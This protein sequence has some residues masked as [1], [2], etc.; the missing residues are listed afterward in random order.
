MVR[1]DF[2]TE[3]FISLD[4]RY[5]ANIFLGDILVVGPKVYI[6]LWFK[7]MGKLRRKSPCLFFGPKQRKWALFPFHSGSLLLSIKFQITSVFDL[8]KPP[9][10][11]LDSCHFCW[12]FKP[13]DVRKLNLRDSTRHASTRL[14]LQKTGKKHLL[15]LA[16]EK[17]NCYVN[18]CCFTVS[19]AILSKWGSTKCFYIYR[20]HLEL[21][22]IISLVPFSNNTIWYDVGIGLFN[23]V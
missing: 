1:I 23:W 10:F 11:H 9:D 17:A 18:S 13:H 20:N 16:S 6:R 8:L 22:T 3:K 5:L 2:S 15:H 4:E 12:Q 7:P 19:A 14:A 21:K